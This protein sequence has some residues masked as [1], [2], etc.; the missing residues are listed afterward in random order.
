MEMNDTGKLVTAKYARE[1]LGL[2]KNCFYYSVARGEAPPPAV[3][4]GGKRHWNTR[5][6]HLFAE[7]KFQRQPDGSWKEVE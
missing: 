5:H 3:V 6:L 2:G 4:L 1:I 7:G